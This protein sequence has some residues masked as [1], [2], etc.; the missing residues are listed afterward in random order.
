MAYRIFTL[1]FFLPFAALAQAS[2]PIEWKRLGDDL[3]IA[4]AGPPDASLFS[5]ELTLLR[6]SLRAF[7]PLIIRAEQFTK[8]RATVKFLCNQSKASV[9]INANYFDELGKPLGLVVSQ[10]NIHQKLHRG[11]QTLTGLFVI[12]RSGPEIVDRSYSK[13]SSVVEG[14]QAG[15][16][17]LVH[18]EP[19]QGLKENSTSTRRSGICI[20]QHRRLILY[21]V[22]STL[23][24][25]T[26]EQ[27]QHILLHRDIGCIEALNLDGGGSTQLFVSGSIP[28]GVPHGEDLSIPGR[29]EVPVALGLFAQE[30]G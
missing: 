15:P 23:L 28:G 8:P 19:P 21:A 5:G 29:D 11:G 4:L 1:I 10:G 9:C 24:G 12:Q 13:L 6:T 20:D 16:R 2:P 22:S 7:R 3:E 14:L 27:T 18:G 17:L 25:L 30:R 26:L